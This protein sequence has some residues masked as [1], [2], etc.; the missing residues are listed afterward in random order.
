MHILLRG[1][2]AQRLRLASGLTLFTFALTHFL[3]HSLGLFSIDTMSLV[4]EWRMAITRSTPGSLI[5]CLALLVHIAFGLARFAR[6][7]TFQLP[8]WELIQ[9]LLGL[10]IPFFLFPHIVNTRI[11]H[12]LFGVNDIYFYELVRLWPSNGWDQS[13]LLLLVWTHGCMGLHFWLRLTKWYKRAFPALLALAVL[14]PVTALAGFMVA[15]RIANDAVANPDVLAAIK[16]VTHWPAPAA[17]ESL[18]S[19][20]MQARYGFYILLGAIGLAMLVRWMMS[21]MQPKVT[22]NYEPEPTISLPRGSTLLEASRM[23]GIPHLSVCGGRARCST[24]RV[25]ILDGLD[26]LPAPNNA[27]AATLAGINAAPD[28]RL[29]CQLRPTEPIAVNVLLRPEG[30]VRKNDEAQGV[31]RTLA[32]LFLDVRGFTSLSEDKLPYDVVYILNRL[33]SAAGTAIESEG[34]WIDKYLGDGLMAVFGRDSDAEDGCRKAIRAAK[35]I[36]LALDQVNKELASELPE[37]I[38]IGMGLHVGSLVLGEIGHERSAAMTVIGRTVNAASRL[39][40]ATKDMKCQFVM[41]SDAAQLAEMDLSD[42]ST[43]SVTVRGLSKP[44]KVV[45]V[46]QAR[47]IT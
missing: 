42:F 24:C 7:S 44:L 41:S 18:S 1:G 28:V 6:R 33:F 19:Y 21:R 29:A 16:Q 4:Q 14:I 3:N 32:V 31:E 46:G 36:D 25:A 9:P 13:I 8:A 12:M 27:E 5:L 10:A 34:G 23:N 26:A 17:G 43:R 15:G 45:I 39:E 30:V 22:I 2:T 37:P 11:A 35:K 20:G 38:S 40:S 47:N